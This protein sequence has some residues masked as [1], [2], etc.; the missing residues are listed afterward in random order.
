MRLLPSEQRQAQ[1][2]ALRLFVESGY[3][4]CRQPCDC[5]SQI[6][7]NNGGNYHEIVKFRIDGGMFW[8][9]KTF[10][11]DYAPADDWHKIA[12][13]DAIEEIADHA[14][15]GWDVISGI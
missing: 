10:T 12:L 15:G 11:G 5:G 13:G 9:S 4:A 1:L 3:I 2:D 14:Q 6:R 7:H 8:R